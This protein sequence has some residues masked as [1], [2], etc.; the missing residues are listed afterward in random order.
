MDIHEKWD[1]RF[2]THWP[3]PGLISGMSSLNPRLR[4]CSG[5]IK[6]TFSNTLLWFTSELPENV[7]FIN[8]WITDSLYFT[9]DKMLVIS[10]L[11]NVIFRTSVWSSLLELSIKSSGEVLQAVTITFYTVLKFGIF[12]CLLSVICGGDDRQENTL[13]WS[14]YLTLPPFSFVPVVTAASMSCS[15]LEA[16]TKYCWV[17]N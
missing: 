5:K 16:E 7:R 14:T 1:P 13:C 15:T 3:S 12:H 4:L 9:F 11:G 6:I 10:I 17:W 8:Q 2:E